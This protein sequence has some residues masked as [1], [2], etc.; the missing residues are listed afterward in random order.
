[1]TAEEILQHVPAASKPHARNLERI[2]RLLTCK[3]VFTEEMEYITKGDSP[4]VVR[5]FALTPLSRVL[6]PGHDSGTMAN[7]VKLTT[8]G[9]VYGKA[10]EHLR[11][12]A[13]SLDFCLLGPCNIRMIL[14]Q[15]RDYSPVQFT[16]LVK[17]H[18]N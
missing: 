10:L 15:I 16:I 6:V 14:S 11:Y 4:T 3:N 8:V 12:S 1:M 17:Q 13:C 5:K 18:E 2:M 9:S 7:F